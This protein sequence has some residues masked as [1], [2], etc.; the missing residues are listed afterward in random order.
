MSGEA[1]GKPKPT[2]GGRQ[3]FFDVYKPGQGPYTRKGTAFGAGILALAGANFLYDQ[4]G[5]YRDERAWTLWLQ[6]GVPILMLVIMGLVI[7]WVVGINRK[8]CDFMIATEGEM[9]KVHWSTRRELI[10][11]TKVVIMFT[12]MTAAILFTVD[13]VFMTFFSWIGVLREAPSVLKIFGGEA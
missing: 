8:A 9:K 5:I 13:L 7:F 11:S 10:G 6:A 1:G 4:L 3:S 2:R 12:M